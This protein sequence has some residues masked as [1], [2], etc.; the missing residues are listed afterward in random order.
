MFS[1]VGVLG[2]LSVAGLWIWMLRRSV[3]TRTVELRHANR[4]LSA[5]KG[6]LRTIIDSSPDTIAPVSYTHLDVYKRQPL[7]TSAAFLP[8]E[9][10]TRK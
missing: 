5:E 8:A 6:R 9:Y 4:E 2:L 7:S 1:A 3:R 10:P